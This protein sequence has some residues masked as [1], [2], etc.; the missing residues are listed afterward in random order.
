MPSDQ[1]PLPAAP[2]ATLMEGRLHPTSLLF[3]V[4][5]AMRRMTWFVVLA[6]VFRREATVVFYLIPPL[7]LM[8]AAGAVRYFSFRWRLDDGELVI[9]QG[10]VGKSER[11]IP[12]DRVQ[13]VRFEQAVLQRML[14]VCVVHVETAGGKGGPEASLSVLRLD[15]AERLRTA[16]FEGR[17]K[18]DAV[19]APA[20]TPIPQRAVLRS[21]TTREL[22]LGGIT[23]TRIASFFLIVAPFF[24]VA[25]DLGIWE[26]ALT[27]TLFERLGSLPGSTALLLGIAVT[28]VVLVGAVVG[29]ALWM[30]LLFHGFALSRA[31]EDLH[32][33]FGLFTRRESSLPRRRIQVLEIE[34]G[35]LRRL[36]GLAAVRADTAGGGVGQEESR[37]TGRDVLIPV[38]PRAEAEAMLS[39]FF[40]GLPAEAPRWTAVDPSAIRRGTVRASVP[41]VLAGVIAL[42]VTGL[43]PGV[44]AATRIAIGAVMVLAVPAI[45]ALNRMS[46]RHLGY[47][48]GDEYFH[49]RRGWLTRSTHV[50]PVRNIQSVAV[51][52]GIFD[53]RWGVATLVVDTAGQAATGGGPRISNI[54]EPEARRLAED[55]SRRAVIRRYRW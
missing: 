34:E 40:P 21:L 18:P 29:S 3:T 1:V 15:D 47:A 27:R 54:P 23:S 42:V 32:R 55:L 19:P 6:V 7:A 38:I 31:G 35:L 48:N 26:N 25:D 49:T 5:G 20:A 41:V 53:R 30:V 46:Y 43:L 13:D 51:L 12:L 9:R 8:M 28:V 52:Q 16:I 36:F 11:H 10:V 2:L 39:A 45:Y 44:N 4:W 37:R 22:I 17:A 33:T 50:V 14:G 24:A